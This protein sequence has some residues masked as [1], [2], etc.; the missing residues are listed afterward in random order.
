MTPER[1]DRNNVPIG[2]G[3]AWLFLL[4]PVR[5]RGGYRHSG[6]AGGPGGRFSDIGSGSGLRAP[7]KDTA[8]GSDALGNPAVHH[9][10]T[11]S[12]RLFLDTQ[13][14][15]QDAEQRQEGDNDPDQGIAPGAAFGAS[16]HRAVFTAIRHSK[17]QAR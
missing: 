16:P 13:N 17:R 2:T 1:P 3:Q 8:N 9:G 4:H 15:R 10:P 7:R 6:R 11:F 5:S 12:Q 14:G